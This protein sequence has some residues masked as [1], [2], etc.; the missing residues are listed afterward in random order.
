[1]NV[2]YQT[3]RLI[4]RQILPSDDQG[5][6]ELD[7]DP[8]VHRFLGGKPVQSIEESR[9][10]IASVRKQYLDFNIGRWA[11]IEKSTNKFLGW[12]G[13]KLNT[14][15]TNGYDQYYDLGYRL[16]RSAWGKG[17]ATESSKPAI[18]H[19]FE[20]LNLPILFANTAK[21]NANSRHVLEKLG[22]SFKEY[23]IDQHFGEC[24]WYELKS[25]KLSNFNVIN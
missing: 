15:K 20:I 5:M 24:A 16:I 6:F 12:S 1:M 23:Y 8:E 9:Q 19:A 17:Y 21:E 22:F 18:F 11:V 2:L 3:D 13:I 25:K 7:S 14:N 10:I 4:L